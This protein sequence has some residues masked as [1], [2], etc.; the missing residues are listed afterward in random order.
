M[1][2]SNFFQNWQAI[3]A[4][5]EALPDPPGTP[6]P[7][8]S[9][10][11]HAWLKPPYYLGTQTLVETTSSSGVPALTLT[12]ESDLS[13][14]L[15][16]TMSNIGIYLNPNATLGLTARTGAAI[17]ANYIA[18]AQQR[19]TA[20]PSTANGIDL[21]ARGT[22]YGNL[23][24]SLMQQIDSGNFTGGTSGTSLWDAWTAMQGPAQ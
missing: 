3:V 8:L 4:A 16:S 2:L 6:A 12:I 20:Y 5:I 13:M 18:T 7:S 11:G 19:A 21:V 17:I 9:P 22:Y 24:I 10:T 15:G 1:K 23:Q 14:M